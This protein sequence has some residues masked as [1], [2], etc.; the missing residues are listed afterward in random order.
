MK[1]GE[2]IEGREDYITDESWCQFI[3][4]L[5]IWLTASFLTAINTSKLRYDTTEDNSNDQQGL[6]LEL[7]ITSYTAIV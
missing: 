4:K 2:E 3:N 5:I 1:L 6:I 7:V